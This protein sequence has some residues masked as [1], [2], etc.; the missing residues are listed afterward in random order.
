MQ[1]IKKFFYIFFALFLVITLT[2][3]LMKTIPGDPF[4]Q[5]KELPTEIYEALKN[6][7]GLNNSLW[8]Q[9][10]DYLYAI[11]HLDFGYSL[12]YTD[13]SVKEIIFESFPVSAMLGVEA[14]MLALP[15]GIFLGSFSA[16]KHGQLEDRLIFLLINIGI[17]IPSFII[18]A[19]IQH[20][21]A[22]KLGL[23]P[24]ARFHTFIHSFL[25]AISLS[26]LPTA[27]I[28]RLVRSQMLEVLKQD[29]IKTAKSKGLSNSA[30]I[31]RHALRN[32]S[33]PLFGYLGQ[34]FAN[35]LTGSFV[36][37]KIFAIPGLGYWFVT[38]VM[39]RDYPLIMGITIFYSALLLLTV[40]ACDVACYILDPRLRKI[41]QNKLYA[42]S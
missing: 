35:I 18:A 12:I 8:K 38:S 25:P 27:F 29:Y 3:V 1:I 19:L 15:L 30:I 5:E 13:R 16:M 23:F 24:I 11:V 10:L 17:S 26:V 6:Y 36:I 32:A 37:E 4:T 31:W 42:F 21:F 22:I 41:N 14:L 7:Y 28:T 20:V 39:S 33:L 9:Y 40:F 34:V 2:F